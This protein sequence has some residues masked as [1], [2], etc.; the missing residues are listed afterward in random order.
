MQYTTKKEKNKA[1]PRVR[2]RMRERLTPPRDDLEYNVR[3][4]YGRGLAFT[5]LKGKVPQLSG[6]QSRDRASIDR[7]IDWI[8]RGC[9][10]GLR[11]GAASGGVVVVDEDVLGAADALNLP[12]AGGTSS[13]YERERRIR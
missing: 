4:G 13:I 12:D 8:D 6:W 11:T 10:I 5:P 9:N 2:E 7:T 1:Q 3:D